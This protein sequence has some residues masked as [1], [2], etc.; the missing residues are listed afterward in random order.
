MN[1]LFWSPSPVSDDQEY[2][3]PTY[4]N[5]SVPPSAGPVLVP[6]LSR[7]HQITYID[8][9]LAVNRTAELIEQIQ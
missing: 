5:D 9:T 3:Y 4:N 2:L 7:E 1:V 8:N 6:L